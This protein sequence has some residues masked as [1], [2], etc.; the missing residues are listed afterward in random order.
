MITAPFYRFWLIWVRIFRLT[1]ADSDYRSEIMRYGIRWEATTR[2][3][4]PC[5]VSLERAMT[6]RSWTRISPSWPLRLEPE[7]RRHR[8]VYMCVSLS[9]LASMNKSALRLSYFRRSGALRA[10][11]S[12]RL[13]SSS[14]V[15]LRILCWV[16]WRGLAP[17][18]LGAE[19]TT[20]QSPAS[21]RA[22]HARFAFSALLVAMDHGYTGPSATTRGRLGSLFPILSEEYVDR[23]GCMQ[24][25]PGF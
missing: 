3:Q 14:V 24:K 17:S 2:W 18:A 20:R 11:W 7:R 12:R 8:R 10:L 15:S 21:S 1:D 25:G 13:C 5:R 19:T 6:P 22:L 9:R 16:F 4:T 23:G